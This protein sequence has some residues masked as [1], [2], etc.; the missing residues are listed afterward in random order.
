MKSYLF[1]AERIADTFF[2]PSY[3]QFLDV[4]FKL[5]FI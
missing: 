1:G 4:H 3:Y 2:F 5:D